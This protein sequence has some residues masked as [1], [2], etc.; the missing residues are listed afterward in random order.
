M[1]Y[2][3]G[4]QLTREGKERNGI[5]FTANARTLG[6]TP[7]YQLT[8]EL[9]RLFQLNR[10]LLHD[11]LTDIKSR[12]DAHQAYFA[13]EAWHKQS[14]LSYNF[15]VSVYGNDALD[16]ET[17]DNAL[18]SEYETSVRQ[19]ADRN[20]GAIDYTLLRMQAVQRDFLCQ[21]WYLAWDD[22]WRR[23]YQAISAM[24]KHEA[25]FSPHYRTSICYRP[26][27]RA[28]LE[29]FLAQRGLWGRSQRRF[30]NNGVLK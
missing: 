22:L 21:W 6:I 1:E 11:E 24:V 7:S 25:D 5:S 27:T 28:S 20:S 19:L 18:Q 29:D 3:D 26:M 14:V 16:K 10:V 12:L 9:A 4:R 8:P 15:L 2:R 13:E 23:N 17:L 30:F